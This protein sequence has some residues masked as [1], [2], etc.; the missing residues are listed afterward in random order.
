M[1]IKGDTTKKPKTKYKTKSMKLYNIS[2][3]YNSC[4]WDEIDWLI[5]SISFLDPWLNLAGQMLV[6]YE[7]TNGLT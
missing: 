5:D 3:F 7:V 2:M 6:I 4:I 1:K